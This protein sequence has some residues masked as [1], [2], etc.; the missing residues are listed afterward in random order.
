[1]GAGLDGQPREPREDGRGRGTAR[2]GD[3]WTNGRAATKCSQWRGIEGNG[4]WASIVIR[5]S[6]YKGRDR[7]SALR[8]R[9]RPS[10]RPPLF[11]EPS[12]GSPP[13]PPP[14]T[15]SARARPN[16]PGPGAAA[17][18]VSLGPALVKTRTRTQGFP[19]GISPAVLAG[20]SK[21]SG[22]S[23][24]VSRLRGPPV[25][26]RRSEARERHAGKV[27]GLGAVLSQ[28][29]SKEKNT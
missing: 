1:M 10:R 18:T 12:T 21:A 27:A 28:S 4:C 3:V 22:P 14:T 23:W 5:R 19:A 20:L 9:R 11:F 8:R 29:L 24:A 15:P 7:V 2:G 13:S 17:A 26:L 16:D 25:S 6:P